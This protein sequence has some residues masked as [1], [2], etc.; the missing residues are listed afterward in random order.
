M[1]LISLKLIKPRIMLIYKVIILFFIIQLNIQVNKKP[2]NMISLNIMIIKYSG[3]QLK[4]VIKRNKLKYKGV[5]NQY[6]YEE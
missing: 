6:I 5:Q 3:V 2:Q 1:N 4:K